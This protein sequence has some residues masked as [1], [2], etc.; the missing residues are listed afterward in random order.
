MHIG[1]GHIDQGDAGEVP[2]QVQELTFQPVPGM[3]VQGTGQGLHQAGPSAPD[4]GQY[5]F[6]QADRLEHHLPAGHHCSKVTS[7]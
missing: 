3:S 6:R 1:V 4:C 7:R 5:E 2:G